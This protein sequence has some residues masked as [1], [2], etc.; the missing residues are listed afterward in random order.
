MGTDPVT[1]QALTPGD[2]TGRAEVVAKLARKA[3][4]ADSADRRLTVLT[5]GKGRIVLART[6]PDAAGFTDG[7]FALWHAGFLEELRAALPAL[8]DRR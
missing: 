8:A 2:Q 3:Q 7:H 4:V 6:S 1:G 5:L